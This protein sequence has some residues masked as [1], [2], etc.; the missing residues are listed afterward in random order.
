M[1]IDEQQLRDAA[2]RRYMK[3]RPFLEHKMQEAIEQAN[4]QARNSPN[5]H[6]VFGER[7]TVV[8][9]IVLKHGHHITGNRQEAE[10]DYVKYLKKKGALEKPK[11]QKKMNRIGYTG[12]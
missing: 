10:T 2:E 1:P 6:P 8:P 11:Y 4:I 3:K 9:D 7:K 12:G 5:S